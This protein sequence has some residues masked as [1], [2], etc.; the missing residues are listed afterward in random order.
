LN[1]LSPQRFSEYINS[2]GQPTVYTIMN[3]QIETAGTGAADYIHDYYQAFATLTSDTDTNWVLT[4]A[5]G[6]YLYAALIESSPFL[7]D[8][9]MFNG[10]LAMYKS[11]V[12]SLNHTTKRY[13][14]GSLAARV[15]M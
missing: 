12:A 9:G 10:W 15:V 11:Q 14:G 13:A 3:N 2:G 6:V 1:Y 8:M 5:P 7:V 4:N